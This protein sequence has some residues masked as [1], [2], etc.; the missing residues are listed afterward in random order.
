MVIISG[1]VMVVNESVIAIRAIRYGI[2]AS[3][4]HIR[5]LNVNARAANNIPVFSK[6]SAPAKTDHPVPVALCHKM[7]FAVE[8]AM[9][10][11]AGPFNFTHPAMVVAGDCPVALMRYMAWRLVMGGV[12]VMMFRAAAMVFRTAS[13]IAIT[14]FPDV[15]MFSACRAVMM[16][17]AYGSRMTI[18]AS[19]I[20]RGPCIA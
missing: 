2:A 16:I 20:V 17:S 3:A 18:S 4:E 12:H 1:R 6:T 19:G 14:A 11:Q 9:D 5:A 10:A 7:P 8:V 13:S 15:M